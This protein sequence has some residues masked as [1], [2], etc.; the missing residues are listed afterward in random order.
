MPGILEEMEDDDFEVYEEELDERDKILYKASNDAVDTEAR[1]EPTIREQP[2]KQ[3]KAAVHDDNKEVSQEGGKKGPSSSSSPNRRRKRGP[4]P[5]DG[6]M[7]PLE[8][9]YEEYL[10]RIEWRYGKQDVDRERRRICWNRIAVFLPQ[11]IYSLV[12]AQIKR[13]TQASNSPI[14]LSFKPVFSSS[15]QITFLILE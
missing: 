15:K 1:E 3:P 4:P 12:I 2:Q 6:R 9:S 10:K 11:P 5:G 8:M 7:D 13:L 14:R